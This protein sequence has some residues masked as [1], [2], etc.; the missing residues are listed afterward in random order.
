MCVIANFTMYVMV[1]ITR[2]FK[3]YIASLSVRSAKQNCNDFF[4]Q[5]VG[6]YITTEFVFSHECRI[7]IIRKLRTDDLRDFIMNEGQCWG[8][9]WTTINYIMKYVAISETLATMSTQY[10]HKQ[11]TKTQ[12]TKTM[13]NIRVLSNGKLK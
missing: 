6:Y 4:Y 10:E 8:K 11:A 13:S 2:I 5:N 3:S 9:W 1:S 12:K 7:Q